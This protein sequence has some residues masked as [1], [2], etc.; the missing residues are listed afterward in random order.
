MTAWAVVAGVVQVLVSSSHYCYS[1]IVVSFQRRLMAPVSV[2]WSRNWIVTCNSAQCQA[3][4][5]LLWSVSIGT[6]CIVRVRV[7]VCRVSS[8]SVLSGFCRVF[9]VCN[10]AAS[11]SR[12]SGNQETRDKCPTA[13]RRGHWVGAQEVVIN[14][15]L[16]SIFTFTSVKDYCTLLTRKMD[17]NLN[18]LMTRPVRAGV[19]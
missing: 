7:R 16:R 13:A 17:I 9:A 3:Q 10:N 4:L 8:F 19:H 15:E 1:T 5:C 6:N 2:K 18:L 12:E 14:M 11:S